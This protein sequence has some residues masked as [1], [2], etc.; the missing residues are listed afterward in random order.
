MSDGRRGTTEGVVAP[1]LWWGSPQR[2]RDDDSTTVARAPITL[3]CDDGAA[4]CES[5]RVADRFAS[6]LRG[7]LGRRGLAPGEGLLIRPASSIHTFFM[8][9]PID[10]AFLDRDGVVVKVVPNLS[11]WRGARPRGVR[12]APQPPG[13]GGA[14]PGPP[15]PPRGG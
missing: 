10:V 5:C 13:G 1:N 11:P 15:P 7:L 8:R 4:V 12:A 3:V 9:F 6:R 14:P 2:E